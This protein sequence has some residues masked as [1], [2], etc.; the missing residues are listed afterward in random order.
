M[1]YGLGAM[2]STGPPAQVVA[3]TD[4]ALR[5]G[6]TVHVRPSTI[7]D[8]GRLRA[9]LESLSEESRWFRFFSAGVNLDERRARRRG[10]RPTGCR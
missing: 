5:D 3:E 4:I 2:T 9:F 10:P 6:S 8:V 7:E 1:P